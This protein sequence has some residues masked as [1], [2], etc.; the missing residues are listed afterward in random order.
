MKRQSKR[1][2]VLIG[3][4]AIAGALATVGAYAYFTNAGSGTGTAT[5]G[6]TSPIVL[7]SDLVG[8]LYPGG[9]DVPVTVNVTNPGGG[10]QYVG[11]V[12]GT[13]ANNGACPGSWFAVDPI[14]VNSTVGAG[15][16]I[17]PSTAV[18][19]NET[20]SNQDACKGLTMTINWTSN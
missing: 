12:S 4:V 2:W 7:S 11:T 6:T 15:L 17:S 8:T 19:M 13:V 18:R 5:V 14:A 10:P 1:A 16:T 9:A 20:G 3:I